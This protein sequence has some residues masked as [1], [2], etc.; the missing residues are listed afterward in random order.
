MGVKE[1]NLITGLDNLC[2][3]HAV[4]LSSVRQCVHFFMSKALTQCV[5]VLNSECV[6]SPGSL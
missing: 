6:E 3:S 1:S 2:D 5:T 4:L